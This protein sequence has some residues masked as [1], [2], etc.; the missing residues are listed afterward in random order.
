MY[1]DWECL[2]AL[3]QRKQLK[4]SKNITVI[5]K[6]D[7]NLSSNMNAKNLQLMQTIYELKKSNE[8]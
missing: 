2:P 4:S 7:N 1:L 3:E 5:W 6:N 8:C